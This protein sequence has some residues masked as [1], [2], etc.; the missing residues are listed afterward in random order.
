MKKL[1]TTALITGSAAAAGVFFTKKNNTIPQNTGVYR[2]RMAPV[3]NIPN[4][5]SSQ[6]EG[7]RYVAPFYPPEGKRNSWAALGEIIE[8][9]ENAEIITKTDDYLHAVFHSP[10]LRFKDDVE[11]YF[12][13]EEGHIDVRSAARVGSYDMGV[14]RERV[15]QLREEYKNA[16]AIRDL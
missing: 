7:N 1:L 16:V 3:S 5:V 12:H 15:E 6:A 14:N 4:A 11:F 13:Q 10:K 2:G 8:R 9:K